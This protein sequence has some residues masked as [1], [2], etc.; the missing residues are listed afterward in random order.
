MDGRIAQ[1]RSALPARRVAQKTPDPGFG[2]PPLPAP[3]R[4][5]ANL[6]APA[7]SAMLSRSAEARMI[8]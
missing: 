6:G 5:T 7:A 1:M 2:E 4:R 3:G 8:G